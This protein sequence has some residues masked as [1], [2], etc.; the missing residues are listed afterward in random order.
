M[1]YRSTGTQEADGDEL[2]LGLVKKSPHFKVIQ[3]QQLECETLLKQS[4]FSWMPQFSPRP[5]W[6]CAQPAA[7]S[8]CARKSYGCRWAA[9]IMPAD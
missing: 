9:A 8:A 1:R 4:E 2:T 3:N 5:A 7:R 6:C